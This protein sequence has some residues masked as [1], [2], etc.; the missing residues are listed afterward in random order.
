MGKRKLWVKFA[1]ASLKAGK[2]TGTIY[3]GKIVGPTAMAAIRA[4][5]MME[6]FEARF[7]LPWWHRWF[8]SKKGKNENNTD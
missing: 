3:E 2:T 8:S 6:E 7:P 1:I 5:S 4:D